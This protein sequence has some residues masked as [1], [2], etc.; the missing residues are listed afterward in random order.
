M[1]AELAAGLSVLGHEVTVYATGDSDIHGTLRYCFEHPV[2]P[3]NDRAELRHATSAWKDIASDPH[4]VDIVHAHHPCALLNGLFVAKPIVFT[5]HHMR[6]QSCLQHYCSYPRAAYVA[7]SRRQAELSPELS[8]ARVIHHGL[9]PQRYPAGAGDGDH[10]AFIGRFA[11]EKAPH[12]AIDAARAAGVRLVMGGSAHE[13]DGAR[14]YFEREVEPLLHSAPDIQWLGELSHG[15]KVQVLSAARALLF[16]LHWEEPFGLI[17]IEA[18]LIGTPVIAFARGS[19]PEIVED[20]V[21]GFLVHDTRQMTQR[22]QQISRLDRAR[23]RARAQ[24]RWSMHRMAAEYADLYAEW[25]QAGP[26]G[27]PNASPDPF[28]PRR[29][30]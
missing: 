21:T 29:V 24:E 14:T 11:R 22:I 7:I 6:V 18:M 8:F 17:M 25:T 30:R 26:T 28:D 9:D 12:V 3:P 1:V 4:G 5:V 16:P 10:V 27:R 19:A 20:G 23:C 13:I 2:W 15:P